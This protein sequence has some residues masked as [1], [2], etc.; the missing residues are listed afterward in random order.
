MSSAAE[1]EDDKDAM[2][3]YGVWVCN[4]KDFELRV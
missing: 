3:N 1:K 4:T 2:E